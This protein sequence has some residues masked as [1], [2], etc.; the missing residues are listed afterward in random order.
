[1]HNWGGSGNVQY[2]DLI[3]LHEAYRSLATA[4]NLFSF[5]IAFRKRSENFSSKGLLREGTVN[6]VNL[7]NFS[8]LMLNCWRLLEI[9][10]CS[11]P[12]TGYLPGKNVRSLVLHIS[13]LPNPIWNSPKVETHEQQINCNF[14]F[15]LSS[16]HS[17]EAF[18]RHHLRLYKSRKI[19]QSN[20]A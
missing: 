6:K 7:W 5:L 11:L 20:W 12:L 9:T 19:K 14:F 15:F 4:N 1:M 3:T 17:R 16:K 18:C 8:K 2:E 10:K 13:I